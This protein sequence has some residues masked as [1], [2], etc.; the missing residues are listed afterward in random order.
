MMLGKE[1]YAP[2]LAQASDAETQAV[3]GIVPEHP[4]RLLTATSVDSGLLDTLVLTNEP[5]D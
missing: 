4:Q 5:T 3:L 1:A 2:N